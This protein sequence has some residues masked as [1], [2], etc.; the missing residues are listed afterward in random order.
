MSTPDTETILIIE[1]EESFRNIYRDMLESGGFYVL[2]AEDGEKGWQMS[3]SEKPDL[4]LLDLNLP[5]L[6]GFE[7]LKNIR[8]DESIKDT[9]VVILTVQGGDDAI[10]KGMDLGATDY[11]TKG[12]CTTLEVLG[13][14][15]SILV[16]MNSRGI[17]TYRLAVKERHL[18]GLALERDTG[19]GTYF[20]CPACRM[21]VCL[22]LTL[23]STQSDSHHFS[24]R[25]VCPK[26]QRHF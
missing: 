24:A 11:L 1:D 15:N 26:C 10:K 12:F 9:P 16:K 6:H 22:E 14:I 19:L 4:I 23:D 25:I 13:K 3:L 7:V 17:N 18:D 8:N 5:K 21:E 20:C 2:I